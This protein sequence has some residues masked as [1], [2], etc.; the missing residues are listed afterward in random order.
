[1]CFLQVP[2]GYASFA[3][4][5][6]KYLS[7]TAEQF[8]QDTKNL[9]DMESCRESFKEVLCR[10]INACSPDEYYSLHLISKEE[11]DE[12]MSWWVI[13]NVTLLVLYVSYLLIDA[14]LF[15]T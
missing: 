6:I 7:K 15:D 2:S 4:K 14:D 10:L 5:Y 13:Y 9:T 1:M 12:K 3:G 8:E 11:C